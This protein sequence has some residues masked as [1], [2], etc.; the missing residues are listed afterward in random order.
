V[1]AP[2]RVV[3]DLAVPE[4]AVVQVTGIELPNVVAF[5]TTRAFGTF[6]VNGDQ[7][8]SEV[9]G[10]W[11][12][13]QEALG[14][15]RLASARQIHGA[16]V[17]AHAGQWR[18]W[19][20]GPAADGH[21]ALEPGTAM[22]VSVADCVPVFVVHPSGAAALLHAGWRGTEAGIATH[23]IER[24]VASGLAAADLTVAFGPSIC[25]RCYEVSPDVHARLTGRSVEQPTPVD[26]RA[27]LAGQARAAGV[28]RIVEC[29]WCTRHH[30]DRFFSHRAGDAGR[31]IAVLLVRE[32]P[33]RSASSA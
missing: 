28:R 23:A 6:G 9:L 33:S 31:Q 30:N 4:E 16:E 3:N 8:V 27:I 26:L 19:L 17:I 11:Q 24:L 2:T 10:R 5:T 14:A 25:G 20:R 18:G 1:T 29:V 7:P 21:L 32:D 12:R 13:L 22:A 15:E